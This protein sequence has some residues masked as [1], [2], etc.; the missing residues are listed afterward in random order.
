MA[1]GGDEEY[2]I[3]TPA[4]LYTHL[5]NIQIGA[6]GATIVVELIRGT[7]DFPL[8]ID[9]AGEDSAEILLPQNVND[10]ANTATQTTIKKT[11]TYITAQDGE[12]WDY[13]VNPGSSTNQFRSAVKTS[14][15]ENFEYVLKPDTYYIINISNTTD[16]LAS[17]VH[18]A[19]FW[20]EEDGS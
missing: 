11:P 20:Y 3:K 1:A 15:G 13:I 16:A 10:V 14:M 8:V 6:T 17:D 4:K 19:M 2:S 5:K 7:E 12:T 18:L 9:S